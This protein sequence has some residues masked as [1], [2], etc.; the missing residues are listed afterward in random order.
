[1][2]EP[3]FP[4]NAPGPFYVE[5]GYCISCEAPWHEAPDLM[6][7]DDGKGGYHCHFKKQPEDAEELE[8]AIMACRVSCVEAVRYAG[9][10][11]AILNRFRQLNAE[12]S[13]DALIG[14]PRRAPTP[15]ASPVP[16]PEPAA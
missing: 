12:Y 15:P 3:P 14:L 7:H 8:R 2:P 16:P 6:D 5:K 4:K 1:M 10:D 13:C 11:P 9:D